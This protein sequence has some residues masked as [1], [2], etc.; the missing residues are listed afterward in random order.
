MA[1]PFDYADGQLGVDGVSLADLASEF[2]TPLYVYHRPTIEAR[3]AAVREAFDDYPTRVCYSVKA[4]SNLRLI[5]WLNAQEVGFDVVS[6]G[7]LTRAVIAGVSAK[8]V[9]FA[10][11]GKTEAELQQA[12]ASK[13]W[14]IT[15]ESVEE[16]V[17]VTRL[18]GAMG[19]SAVPVALRINPD[20]DALTHPH[21]TTGRGMDKFGLIPAEFEDALTW[22]LERPE[23]ELVGLHMH[24]GSQITDMR[25]YE[26]GLTEVVRCANRAQAAGAPLKWINA[27]GG[28][29]ISYDGE[30][31]PAVAEF[32]AAIV[33]AIRS[34]GVEL[35]LELGRFLVG[36]AGCLLT[37][38]LY[39]KPRP[40]RQLAIVDG[41][42]T[43][44]LRPALYGA[45]HRVLPVEE[46][47]GALEPTDVAGPICEST[48]YLAR[49]H[50]LP[51]LES[52][53][54]L[55]I[56]DAGAY[57]MSMVSHYNSHPGPAEV[58]ITED[59]VVERIR[60]RETIEDLLA[61]DMEA[62]EA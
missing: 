52:G 18:A 48:D 55:A 6:A 41:G 42:M 62:F 50:P 22:V 30:S 8:Q 33:P 9:V 61:I 59:G 20:V 40:D 11:V 58:W 43:T 56:L 14:M 27:G 39:N 49:R 32:A 5:K 23:V 4:N 60:R 34:T 46:H 24:L 25:P 7:E 45:Q 44:L 35:V 3:L 37:T 19:C 16:A 28:F 10:G 51:R 17:A 13:L 54:T 21:I 57:G 12:V 15:L 31:V 1:T 29:G 26:Q 53:A 47:N 36:P 38:V 2:G